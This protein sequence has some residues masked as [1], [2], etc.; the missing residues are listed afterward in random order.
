MYLDPGTERCTPLTMQAPNSRGKQESRAARCGACPARERGSVST[1][2]PPPSELLDRRPTI[3]LCC[4]GYVLPHVPCLNGKHPFARSGRPRSAC[5]VVTISVLCEIRGP[6]DV[7]CLIVSLL[8][9][10]LPGSTSRG[11][12]VAH[13]TPRDACTGCR[14]AV[15][16]GDRAVLRG[17]VAVIHGIAHECHLTPLKPRRARR[18]GDPETKALA[19][20]LLLG[21]H[22]SKPLLQA[23]HR[24]AQL[25]KLAARD[26]V[27]QR[28]RLSLPPRCCQPHGFRGCWRSPGLL[29]STPAAQAPRLLSCQLQRQL[30]AGRQ[31]G[32]ARG[33]GDGQLPCSGSVLHAERCTSGSRVSMQPASCDPRTHLARVSSSCTRAAT[34]TAACSPASAPLIGP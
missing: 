15:S 24:S 20:Q 29:Q 33:R 17:C 4:G 31:H 10:L 2:R 22:T 23:A 13:P 34:C 26:R 3:R 6:V 12:R 30:A 25:R 8:Q 28:R 9:Q 11:A 32:A 1:T 18:H 27:P 5:R 14:C 7:A 19:P 16:L 21:D